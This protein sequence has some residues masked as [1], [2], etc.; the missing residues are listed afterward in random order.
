MRFK[1]LTIQQAQR[2]RTIRFHAEISSG[3]IMNFLE[4]MFHICP[5]AG[6]GVAESSVIALFLVAIAAF[7]LHGPLRRAVSFFKN[8]AIYVSGLA[9]HHLK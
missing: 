4:Q 2:S 9:S 5:D 7:S 6:N 1:P 8:R 3:E